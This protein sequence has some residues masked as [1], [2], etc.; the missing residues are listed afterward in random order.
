MLEM[1]V[2]ACPVLLHWFC[3]D[4]S[5]RS[6]GGVLPNAQEPQGVSATPVCVSAQ[7]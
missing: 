4:P 3:R 2:L 7:L 5:Q 1:V 6:A